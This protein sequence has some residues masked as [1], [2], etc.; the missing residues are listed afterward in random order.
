MIYTAELKRNPSRSSWANLFT[1]KDCFLSLPESDSDFCVASVWPGL[2]L[3][4]FF[5]S[6]FGEKLMRHARSDE[7]PPCCEVLV[8]QGT[9]CGHWEW[10]TSADVGMFSCS[11]KVVRCD[12]LAGG[13]KMKLSQNLSAA[14]RVSVSERPHRNYLKRGGRPLSRCVEDSFSFF[15]CGF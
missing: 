5:F 10:F 8:L 6:C 15:F 13:E 1:L 2:I 9:V 11:G 3:F 14:P 12:G 7:N 4:F